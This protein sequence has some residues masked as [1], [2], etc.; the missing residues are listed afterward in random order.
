MTILSRLAL[1]LLLALLAPDVA[2]ADPTDDFI[3]A[4]MK[5][6]RIPGLSVAIV[7][8]GQIVKT[9]GYGVTD[10]SRKTPATPDTV[11]KIASVSKQ[12]IATG[13]MLLVAVCAR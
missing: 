11:Y 6:Q 8:D 4:E 12:F 1:A 5:R 10:R 7:K 13:I 3:T 9:A 2:W